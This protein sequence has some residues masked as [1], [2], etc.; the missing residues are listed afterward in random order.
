MNVRI[1][2]TKDADIW[3]IIFK[4]GEVRECPRWV[5]DYI[6]KYWNCADIIE[7]KEE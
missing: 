1:R 4:K 6:I 5:A 3:G 7:E 2:F